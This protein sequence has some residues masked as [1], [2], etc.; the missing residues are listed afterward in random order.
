MNANMN[1]ANEKLREYINSVLPFRA[2]ELGELQRYGYQEGYPIITK[3]SAALM[4]V[5]LS[6]VRPKE[7][8][9]LGTAIGFSACFMADYLREGGKVTTIDRYPLMIEQAKENI[10]KLG[11]T[12]RIRMIEGD[13]N[14]VV[15]QL[16]GEFDVIFMD[17]GKGQ[18]IKILP[19]CLRLL[20]AGGL[21]IAD[22]I[23]LE[24]ELGKERLEVKRR[25]RT[26]WTRLRDFT[27]A[28][29]NDERLETSIL[30]VGGGMAVCRKLR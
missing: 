27:E 13:I 19:D 11:K 10:K 1:V 28:L 25:D 5:L 14:E 2:G 12:D 9:E 30:T 7:I 18:Y 22:D 3:E 24:G 21:L 26:T 23:L 6:L 15:S 29:C 8:L 20:R 16:K 17:G 4:A